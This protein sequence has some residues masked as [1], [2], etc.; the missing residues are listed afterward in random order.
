[1]QELT[2]EY[3]EPLDRWIVSTKCEVL[4]KTVKPGETVEIKGTFQN[5]AWIPWSAYLQLYFDGTKIYEKPFIFAP[6]EEGSVSQEYTIPYDTAEG[7]HEAAAKTRGETW[8]ERKV[9]Y[10]NV[11]TEPE[12]G[13][14][15]LSIVTIPAGASAYINRIL[16]GTTPLVIELDPGYYDLLLT[17][18]GYKDI[19]ERIHVIEG[20]TYELFFTLEPSFV[21]PWKWIA[22]GVA[23]AG[24]LGLTYYV[25]T[26]K[27]EWPEIA[28][29]R[30]RSAY[31]SARSRYE[32]AAPAVKEAARREMERAKEAYER[33]RATA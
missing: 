4:P 9:D 11:I 1:M 21:I 12:P 24:A 16:Y 19:E 32:T 22:A 10:V 31:E 18:E 8:E 27:P 5:L 26:R 13:K 2:E 15:K 7:A 25:A 17:L 23:I 6:R 14:G 28:I 33:L 20:V 3:V 30:A 29:E